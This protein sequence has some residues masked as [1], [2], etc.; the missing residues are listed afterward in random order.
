MG[1]KVPFYGKGL[2]ILF[3]IRHP[4]FLKKQKNYHENTK[5]RVS[6]P[7]VRRGGLARGTEKRREK[8]CRARIQCGS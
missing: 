7:L 1:K 2:H 3:A 4:A 8:W 5:K 6:H